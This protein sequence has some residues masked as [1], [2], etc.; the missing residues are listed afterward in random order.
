MTYLPPA[1]HKTSKHDS[2]TT[3][4]NKGRTTET[5]RIQIQIEASQLLI[6]YKPR[7]WPLGFTISTLMST[8]TT[9]I[10]KFKIWIQDP[11]STARRPKAKKKLKKVI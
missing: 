6:T 2:P 7:Y 4:D 11:W 9:K 5:S 10:T 1:H 8:L 3:I